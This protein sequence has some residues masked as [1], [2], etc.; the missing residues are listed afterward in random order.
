MGKIFLVRHSESVAN[1]KG[2]YQGQTF[3]TSL[4]KLGKVQAS[5]LADYLKSIKFTKIYTSPLKRTI[6]T[7]K[8]IAEF[9]NISIIKD[10]SIIE[11][12]H[13]LWE[14]LNKDVIKDKWPDIYNT[15]Q[16][17]PANAVFPN[18]ES[19]DN[20]KTRVINWLENISTF[21]GNTL[22]ITH[23]NII[24]IIVSYVLK[25]NL[26]SIWKHDIQAASVTIVRT[27][28]DHSYKILKIGQISHL[29]NL[30]ADLSRH[31]L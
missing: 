27:K 5:M 16:S 6:E 17:S 18:G 4:S 10:N 8:K 3:D 13:G 23:D 28:K 11:T 12:N 25:E 9:Q 21:R 19:F 2:I 7:A 31:A 29:D 15:W 30:L 20:T 26:N 22:V 14:G 1:T 24:R